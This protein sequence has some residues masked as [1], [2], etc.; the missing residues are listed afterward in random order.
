MSG[1]SYEVAAEFP[2]AEETVKCRSPIASPLPIGSKRNLISPDGLKHMGAIEIRRSIIS[3]AVVVVEWSAR[4]A[5][6]TAPA[7]DGGESR[8]ERARVHGFGPSVIGL[9]GQVVEP[10]V[11]SSLK[12]VIGRPV[13]AIKD[14]ESARILRVGQ[15]ESRGKTG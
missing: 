2:T 6:R 8:I 10:A 7:P 3:P 1:F 12:R 14:D 11:E 13:V 15:K 4:R 9:I 5:K